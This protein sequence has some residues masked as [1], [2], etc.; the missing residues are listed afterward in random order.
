VKTV[1]L[2]NHSAQCGGAEHALLR[3]LSGLR[4]QDGWVP[5]VFLQE[6]GPLVSRLRDHSVE[7]YVL[8]MGNSLSDTRRASL[9]GAGMFQPQKG[10]HALAHVG[11]LAL[12]L[13]DRAVDLVHTNSMKAHVLGG[14]A[15]RMA[16]IPLVWHLRDS[17]EE[18][19]LPLSAVRTMRALARILPERILCVSQAVAGSI[20]GEAWKQRCSVVYDGLQ[21][22]AFETPAHPEPRAVIR[23]GMVGR[24]SPWKGQHLFLEA[25]GILRARGVAA[26]FELCGSPLFGEDAYAEGLKT[27]A[28]ALGIHSDVYFSG[29]V[30]DVCRRIRQWDICVHASTLPD[31]CPNVVLESMAAGVPV[32]G[33]RGGGVPELL[34]NGGCGE[35]FPMGDARALAAALEDL[36]QDTQKR[37]RLAS[38]ARERALQCFRSERVVR[39]VLAIWNQQRTRRPWPPGSPF[40]PLDGAPPRGGH[41]QTGSPCL[42]RET[43]ASPARTARSAG[44]EIIGKPLG[45]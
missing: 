27:Q 2:I 31:P 25:A 34:E 44:N 33:S 15:A 39:E 3:L 12:L 5:V 35:L 29:W 40:G 7:T 21:P 9:T 17:I 45:L 1:A 22:E 6:N 8:P 42:C 4:R 19:S 30:G 28:Q 43:S 24:F 14:M 16:G 36:A 41:L 13:R 18:A 11:K 23:I 26:Q 37:R 32:V 10:V 20:A 38:R